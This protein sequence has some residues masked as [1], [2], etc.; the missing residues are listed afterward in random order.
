MNTCTTMITRE[1]PRS[2][3]WKTV[4]EDCNLACDYCYY[5]TCAGKPG[6]TIRTIEDDL[7]DRVVKQM[8]QG[9]KGAVSFAWQ[10]G[11]PLLAGKEFFHK[12]VSL[13]AHYA[14]PRTTISNSVQTNGTLIDAEW[15]AFFKTY[16]FLVG[17]SVDGPES[18]HDKRRKTGS[19]AG[20]YKQVMRGIDALRK[21]Q[22]S[23]NILMV[24]HEDNVREASALMQWLKDQQITFAQFIPCMDFRSQ[25]VEASG[26]Y[27][28]SPEEYGHF[29][30]EMFDLWL[31]D[32]EPQMSIRIFDNWLQTL[33]GDEPE[34]CTFR[35]SCPKMLI[36]EQNGD[37]YPCDFY[38]HDQYKLGSAKEASLQQLM[39]A[40]QWELFEE[41]QEQGTDSCKTC[42][43]WQYCH[44]GCPRNRMTRTGPQQSLQ[45]TDYFCQS[46]RM[47]YAYG[48][49]RMRQL[50][51][52]VMQ[53][54]GRSYPGRNERCICGSGKKT[55]QCCGS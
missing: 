33:I 17:V 39:E 31:E 10:G 40:P 19:G 22:V 2:I 43:Y 55:K 42:S 3:M 53:R 6:K 4:S 16:S 51:K 46:Y 11:E 44:G 12:V 48:E 34:M 23:F 28:I 47:L 37:A 21:E 41:Q 52:R 9:S 26:T 35:Q 8:M 14:Q 36:L 38:I 20:S 32:G 29:L 13:Q 24:I 5:S 15:A 30:C 49:D 18:I 7:L 45:E 1:V 54:I 25:D 27:R 50:A